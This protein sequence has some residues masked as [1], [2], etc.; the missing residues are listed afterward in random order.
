MRGI[1]CRTDPNGRKYVGL[2]CD[3]KRRWKEENRE[4]LKHLEN[5]KE[6]SL[7][8]G[9]NRFGAHSF[10]NEVV[11]EIPYDYNKSIW[12]NA[13]FLSMREQ[14]WINY[15]D[16]YNNGYNLTRGGSGA[17]TTLEEQRKAY[18]EN[19]AIIKKAIDDGIT[20][21]LF[22]KTFHINKAYYEDLRAQSKTNPNRFRYL[23]SKNELNKGEKIWLE[24]NKKSRKKMR[25]TKDSQVGVVQ[26]V[27]F[28]KAE[29]ELSR[30]RG[31]Q[32]KKTKC[33]GVEAKRGLMIENK[34]WMEN[35]HYAFVNSK[36]T[37]ITKRRSFINTPPWA[38]E[39]LIDKGREFIATF[40]SKIEK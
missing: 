31:G 24:R 13:E 5:H 23:D 37:R 38:T 26:W 12:E 15:F 22:I 40:P 28:T 27:T 17:N 35:G 30:A 8:F 7:Y 39:S 1:Y 32:A 10:I 34:I 20:Q 9:L 19:E 25:I 6:N 29:Y 14:Y 21:E 3:I 36:G 16:S 2:S 11:E 4:A 33:K 18:I